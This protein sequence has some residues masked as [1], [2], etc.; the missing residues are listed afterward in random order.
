MA[1][2]EIIIVT[3]MK[4]AKSAKKTVLMTTKTMIKPKGERNAFSRRSFYTTLKAN[5]EGGRGE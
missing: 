5:D 2:A 1:S 4:T 3:M